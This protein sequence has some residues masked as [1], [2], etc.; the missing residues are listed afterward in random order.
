[1]HEFEEVKR[2][3]NETVRKEL[4]PTRIVRVHIHEGLTSF[5]EDPAYRIGVIFDGDLP[6]GRKSGNLQLAI[7]Q[8][9]W[10][11]KDERYPIVTLIR[12]ENEAKHY[13]PR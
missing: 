7:E 5:G 8:H 10:K 13:A 11:I 9:L 3:I 6:D 4:A 2:Y 1:M 12:V